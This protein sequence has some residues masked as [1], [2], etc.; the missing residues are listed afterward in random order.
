MT[1]FDQRR[2][3]RME[4][5]F[6]DAGFD[7]ADIARALVAHWSFVIGT[8]A[9]IRTIGARGDAPDADEIFEFNLRSWILGL[10]AKA[11]NTSLDS[12]PGRVDSR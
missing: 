12:F 7:D 1:R 11:A 8:L 10:G 4:Q 6:H 5:V 3:E 2:L 9:L